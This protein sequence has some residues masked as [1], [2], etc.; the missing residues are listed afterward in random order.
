[1]KTPDTI[2]A[3]INRIRLKIYEKTKH[4]TRA[5]RAEHTNKIAE[6]YD[7]KILPEEKQKR[8]EKA[9]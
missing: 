3:E 5:Q 1:M 9:A 2:E 6:H 8:N 4:M 7:F